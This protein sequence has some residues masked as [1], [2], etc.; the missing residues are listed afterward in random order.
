MYIQ[1]LFFNIDTASVIGKLKFSESDRITLFLTLKIM[2]DHRLSG[3][4]RKFYTSSPC[5]ECNGSFKPVHFIRDDLIE[6][7]VPIC[8]W[9]RPQADVDVLVGRD[10]CFLTVLECQKTK[11]VWKT[12]AGCWDSRND[13]RFLE[14][15]GPFRSA[16]YRFDMWVAA[17][18]HFRR[19]PAKN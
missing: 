17:R 15:Y 8:G 9:G 13:Q 12:R 18:A 2:T 19:E 6:V 5:S 3:I 16:K 7:C 10:G 4:D 1:V 14:L 11:E